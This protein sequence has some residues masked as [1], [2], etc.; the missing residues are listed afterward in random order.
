MKL[1]AV[2]LSLFFIFGVSVVV[3]QPEVA[4]ADYAY[5]D[6]YS[7]ECE[8]RC[9]RLDDYYE[10]VQNACSW[11]LFCNAFWIQSAR[12]RYHAGQ[13]ENLSNWFINNCVDAG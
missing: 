11:C 10:N 3:V 6:N 8:A 7:D 5:C 1:T 4:Q 9:R 13:Y 12:C 2:F